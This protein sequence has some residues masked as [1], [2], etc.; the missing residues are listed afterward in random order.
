MRVQILRASRARKEVP[1]K[2][3]VV[4]QYNAPAGELYIAHRF[5]CPA[6]TTDE[7][8]EKLRL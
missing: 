3:H 8:A 1:L 7:S 2:G 4:A 5:A 6:P